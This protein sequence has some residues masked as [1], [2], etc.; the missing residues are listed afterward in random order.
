MAKILLVEDE[1]SNQA[2]V[3]ACLSQ[4]EISIAGTLAEARDL[5]GAQSWDLILLDLNLPDGSGLN[6][7]I[8]LQSTLEQQSRPIL[9]LFTS[10]AEATDKVAGYS[11]GADE[12]ITKPI[13]PLVFKAQIEALLRRR[14]AKTTEASLFQKD[15]FTFDMERQTVKVDAAG[16]EKLLALTTLEFRLLLYF[17]KKKDHV[18]SREKLIAEVWGDNLNITDRTVD[19]HISHLRKHLANTSVT[20]QAVYGAGYRLTKA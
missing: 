4:N 13:E 11:M 17:F 15:G 12:Y 6:F 14:G 7:M 3:K 2:I 10:K 20:L 5:L 8:E 16:D 19:S 9:A 1:K 18:L